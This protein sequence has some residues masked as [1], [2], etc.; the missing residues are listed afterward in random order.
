MAIEFSPAERLE[1]ASLRIA[2]HIRGMWEEKGSSDTRLLEA[3]FL[4]DELTVVGRSR[5]FNGKGRREHVVPRLVIIK[6]CH[7]MI[8]AGETDQAVAELI[9]NHAKI[10]LISAEECERLDRS[11]HLGLRQSMPVGWKFGDD[12]FARL[13]MAKIEWDP[14]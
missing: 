3:L 13:N 14:N 10:V 1:R 6:E 12:V 9:R 7:R 11:A 8:E 5:A 4:P 2:M